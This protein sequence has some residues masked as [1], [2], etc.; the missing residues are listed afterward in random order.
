MSSELPGPFRFQTL[1][2]DVDPVLK[3]G[4]PLHLVLAW[5]MLHRQC[6]IFSKI[7]A[8]GGIRLNCLMMLRDYALLR[9]L[10][11]IYGECASSYGRSS[12]YLP[13]LNNSLHFL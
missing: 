13:A 1:L 6:L 7:A 4:V 2:A 3:V 9:K 8:T 10:A 5:H 11:R 12:Y